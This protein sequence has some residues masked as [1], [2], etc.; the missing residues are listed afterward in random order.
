VDTLTHAA[1]GAC[2]G[3]ALAGRRIGLRKAAIIGGAL[4][5]LPDLDVFWPHGDPVDSFVFHRSATHS[6]LMQALAAPILGEILRR[7]LPPLKNARALLYALVFL[8]LASHSILDAFTNYGTRLFWPL[9][10]APLAV[11]SIF[12]IDPLYTLPLLVAMVWA[13]AIGT[14]NPRFARVLA[15]AFALSSLYM[16]WTLLAQSIATGRATTLLAGLGLKPQ[17]IA[18]TPTPLNT[19]FWRVIALDG[20]R[21]YNIYVPMLAGPGSI[22][23]YVQDSGSALGDCLA[24]SAPLRALS[25]FN[26]AFHG[27]ELQDNLLIWADLRMGLTPQYTFRFAI[28]ERNGAGFAAIAP[29][30]ARLARDYEAD[31]PWLWAG[32]RGEPIMRRSEADKLLTPSAAQA[33]LRTAPP[34]KRVC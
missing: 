30:R 14:W 2:I 29:Q 1:L 21:Y 15:I 33:L 18:A 11:G 6:L 25:D 17:Q 24:P 16:G 23:A 3:A 7:F 13:L 32:I 12:V 27:F 28:A 19:M 8:C 34:A 4:A 10:P 26:G 31:L 5:N 20:P 22:A 9:W